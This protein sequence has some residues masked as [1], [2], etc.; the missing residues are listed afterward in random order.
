MLKLIQNLPRV[1]KL[2]QNRKK[3]KKDIIRVN[4]L[5]CEKVCD[6]L[7]ILHLFIVI[8]I[9]C[10]LLLKKSLVLSDHSHISYV[11]MIMTNI[12]CNYDYNC[13]TDFFK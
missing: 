5:L 9:E 12:I 8:Y 4:C 3:K 1:L 13:Y 7:Y 6:P 10:W 2:I 11:F